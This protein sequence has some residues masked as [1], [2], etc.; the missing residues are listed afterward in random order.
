MNQAD[1]CQALP[2]AIQQSPLLPLLSNSLVL[3]HIAPYL[4]INSILRLAATSR[5]FRYLIYGNPQVFRR[6]DLSRL[7][8]VRFA[9][10]AIDHGG[11]TWRNE[12]VDENLT[13]DE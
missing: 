3:S 6:L 5:A 8:T 12:Q 10:G 13:E 4:P 9:I 7:K 11:E 2:P 1:S